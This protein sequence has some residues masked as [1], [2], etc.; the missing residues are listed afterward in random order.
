MPPS[1]SSN[2]K[3]LPTARPGKQ[4]LKHPEHARNELEQTASN[5]GRF[6]KGPLFLCSTDSAARVE[7][8]KYPTR[9]SVIQSVHRNIN[10][11][12][13]AWS[14]RLVAMNVTAGADTAVTRVTCVGIRGPTRASMLEAEPAGKPQ[15]NVFVFPRKQNRL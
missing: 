13:N 12:V 7:V 9:A 3:L 5:L 11:P 4:G 2:A 1:V 10:R 8:G 15:G 14:T 6:C